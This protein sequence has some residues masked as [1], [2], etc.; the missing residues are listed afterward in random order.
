MQKNKYL[1]YLIPGQLDIVDG[2]GAL[3][4]VRISNSAASADICLLGAHLMSYK[5][6]GERDLLWMSSKSVFEDGNALRGGIPICWPWFGAPPE[7]ASTS[8]GYARYHFWSLTSSRALSSDCT[9]AVFTYLPDEHAPSAWPYSFRLE[10]LVRVGRTL[11]LA[12]TTINTDQVPFT[13]NQALHTY[14]NISD[15]AKIR[16]QGFHGLTYHDTVVKDQVT[17]RQQHGEITFRS[18][19]DAVFMDCTGPATILDP[20]YGR[21]IFIEKEN[22]SSAV[23]WNPWDAKAKRMSD[24]GAEEYNRMVCVECC[25]IR[26]DA[27]TILPQQCHTLKTTISSSPLSSDGK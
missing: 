4:V 24:F 12:L 3:P 17:Y 2:P 22:S 19:T 23:V 21:K 27:R 6:C 9:E 25:N 5:P 18:E 26:A 10:F 13:V 11:E 1:P 16:I 14:Y 7:G 8:H 20:V 15:I